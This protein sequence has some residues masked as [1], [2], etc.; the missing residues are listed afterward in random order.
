[1]SSNLLFNPITLKFSFICPE[2]RFLIFIFSEKVFLSFF[3]K[4]KDSKSKFPSTTKVIF[5]DAFFII[6]SKVSK[7]LDQSFCC[8]LIFLLDENSNIRCSL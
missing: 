1:M 4:T 7:R 5:Y 2:F 3:N 8:A 6:N